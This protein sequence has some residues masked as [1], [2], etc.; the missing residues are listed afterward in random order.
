MK[1]CGHHVGF[2]LAVGRIQPMLELFETGSILGVILVPL[3]TMQWIW[4]CQYIAQVSLA[5]WYSV[6][7]TILRSRVRIPV[8]AL[9]FL[10]D[11][12]HLYEA[13]IYWVYSCDYSL[14]EAPWS[15]LLALLDFI[16][17]SY[18]DISTQSSAHTPW[19]DFV[20]HNI[21]KKLLKYTMTQWKP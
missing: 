10:F 8:V 13:M 20:Y 7:M 5:Y 18:V 4:T 19:L 2:V 16:H 11:S 12:K 21:E 3:F 6:G 15:K 14:L 17:I 1:W 9:S